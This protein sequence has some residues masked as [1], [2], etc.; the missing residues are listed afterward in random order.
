MSEAK[1]TPGPWTATRFWPDIE[2]GAETTDGHLSV[3]WVHLGAKPT[4][5][6]VEE[7][8][9]DARVLAA[10]PE[11]LD[12]LKTTLGNIA[13]LKSSHP[14]VSIFDVW[15]QVVAAAIA[16]AEGRQP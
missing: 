16:R 13:S 1:H 6:E 12:A 4:D 5:R 11:M 15:E 10:S 9:R 14:G 3:A 2:I 7:G 8:M